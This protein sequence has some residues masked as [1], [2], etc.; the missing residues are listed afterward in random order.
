MF[1]NLIAKLKK[2]AKG[3][4]KE[5]KKKILKQWAS[6]TG[7]TWTGIENLL[8]WKDPLV[9]L[10]VFIIVTG[11]FW[12]L[13]APK[14]QLLGILVILMTIPCTFEETRCYLLS[15]LPGGGN[16]NRRGLGTNNRS[17][18][19]GVNDVYD[20]LAELWMSLDKHIDYLLELKVTSAAMFYV[21]TTSYVI[22]FYF[23]VTY[24]P[25]A[26]IVYLLFTVMYFT[27]ILMHLDVFD[28]LFRYVNNNIAQ[29]Q[30]GEPR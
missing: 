16:S 5:D 4:S 24:L 9:S 20:N 19:F 22:M 23:V 25:I 15:L 28:N 30:Q 18:G 26:G 17:L 6:K 12:K 27:P 2:A 21:V 1:R 8:F 10:A 11:L 14:L 7:I 29:Q 3:N 13:I